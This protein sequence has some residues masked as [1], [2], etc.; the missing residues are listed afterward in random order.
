MTV[1]RAWAGMTAAS[2][3]MVGGE[4]FEFFDPHR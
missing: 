4:G 1:N 2:K 3:S